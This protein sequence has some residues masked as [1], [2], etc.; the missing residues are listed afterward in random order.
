MFYSVWCSLD[1]WLLH[2]A[3]CVWCWW[4]PWC[5]KSDWV[6]KHLTD[7]D[8]LLKYMEV[9]WCR[10]LMIIMGVN[11]GSFFNGMWGSFLALHFTLSLMSTA[12]ICLSTKSLSKGTWPWRWLRLQCQIANWFALFRAQHSTAQYS[13]DEYSNHGVM[14]I[15][16]GQERSFYAASPASACHL[17]AFLNSHQRCRCQ[18]EA[19]KHM[20][21]Q[22]IWYD[23]D[24]VKLYDIYRW[25]RLLMIQ[26]RWYDM[27]Y[28][29][30]TDFWTHTRGAGVRV[31]Q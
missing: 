3:Q 6:T 31:K 21:I 19:V 4:D 12:L 22:I 20:M 9:M 16:S 10:S 27:I 14:M 15:L 29:D 23:T 18:S 30:D 13:M 7:V 28:T 24:D 26:I 2:A 25:Y 17:K 11:Y 8:N 1:G 5:T